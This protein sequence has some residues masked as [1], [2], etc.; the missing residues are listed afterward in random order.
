LNRLML[1]WCLKLEKTFNAL[2]DPSGELRSL[3]EFYSNHE[4]KV[5]IKNTLILLAAKKLW[6]DI[7]EEEADAKILLENV[8]SINYADNGI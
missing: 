6:L 3:S 4:D 7:K 1:K 8:E 2:E 5:Q